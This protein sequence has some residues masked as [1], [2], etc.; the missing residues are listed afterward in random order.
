[1]HPTITRIPP[2]RPPR[3]ARWLRETRCAVLMAMLL[4]GCTTTSEPQQLPEKPKTRV[5]FIGNSLTYTNNLPALLQGMAAAAGAEPFTYRMIAYGGFSLE[6]HWGIQESHTSIAAD[7]W[8][9][10][11]LQQGSSALAEGRRHLLEF[12]GRYAGEIRK[13]GSVPALYAV[14][15]PEG[16]R[17]LFDAVAE[18]YRAAAAEAGG[19]LFPVGEAWRAA[20]RR[21]STIRFYSSDSL[22][23]TPAGSYLAALVMFQQLYG[24][25]PVGLPSTIPLV[26]PWTGAVEIPP[27][28][29]AIL[30]EA[31]AEANQKYAL[32]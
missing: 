1:M 10:V 20:W 16:Y 15:P 14:W 12:S 17:H 25:S 29:A 28:T 30:Q 26:A 4:I 18:S 23:P 11:V 19:M 24:R 9:V 32:R 3:H 22:H 27:A 8:D 21:D 7:K 13:A 31:A 5:L 6:E 2:Y